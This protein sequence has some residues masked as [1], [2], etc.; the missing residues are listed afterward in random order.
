MAAVQRE[1]VI[2]A[3]SGSNCDKQS[4]ISQFDCFEKS[5]RASIRLCANLNF[6]NCIRKMT[7]KRDYSIEICIQTRFA[8][9]RFIAPMH[10]FSC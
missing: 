9:V 10:F 2:Q 6:L 7:C 3:Q 8:I 5:T 1:C 4:S